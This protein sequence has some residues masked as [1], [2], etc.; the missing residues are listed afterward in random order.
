MLLFWS[1]RPLPFILVGEG[2][3]NGSCPHFQCVIIVIREGI[4]PKKVN[5]LCCSFLFS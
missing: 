5:E 1:Y 2:G 3:R 4:V